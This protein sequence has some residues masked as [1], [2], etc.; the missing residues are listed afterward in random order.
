[1]HTAALILLASAGFGLGGCKKLSETAASLG[2]VTGSIG[3]SRQEVPADEL[4]LQR[5]NA[6]Y[7]KRYERRP[8]D[9]DIAMAYARGLRA[10]QRHEQAIAVLQR[11]ALKRPND[12]ELLADYGKA[13]ADGGRLQEAQQVLE[14][15]FVPERPNWS[16]LSAQGSVAGKLGN[17][18]LAQQYYQ[19]ALKI[20][21]GEPSVLSN[22]GL[23]YALGRQLPEAENALRQA[24]THPRSD[25]RVRQNLALVLALQGKF[26]EAEEVLRQVLGP[27]DATANV[28]S[29]RSMIAQSNTW[30]EIQ[31]L[32]DRGA[33][34]AS[35]ARAR[36]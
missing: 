25:R 21:P 12:L 31:T 36:S 27:A 7:A 4:G 13:L 5:Y 34:P 26:S 32:G 11:A 2:D 18:K 3:S 6:D 16:I 17:N 19:D 15:A 23:S 29:I 10:A 1:M 28:A 8:E 14:Q 22:L 9:R 20:A 33:R 24:V 35:A 30:R